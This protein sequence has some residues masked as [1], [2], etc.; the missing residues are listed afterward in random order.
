MT[1]KVVSDDCS[2]SI[3]KRETLKTPHRRPSIWTPPKNYNYEF[4]AQDTCYGRSSG[5][6]RG[7]ESSQVKL[8][9]KNFQEHGM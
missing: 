1:A 4:P 5:V 9:H 7:N 3:D 6:R 8:L 2:Q